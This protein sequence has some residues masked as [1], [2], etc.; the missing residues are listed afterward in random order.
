MFKSLY[1]KIMLLFAIF[2]AAVMAAV[3]TILMDS[4]YRFYVNEF[5][6]QMEDCLSEGSRSGL[7][8]ELISAL[9]DT[10]PPKA[11][12]AILTAYGTRLGIDEYRSFYILDMSGKTLAGSREDQNE[13]PPLTPNLISAMSGMDGSDTKVGDFTPTMPPTSQTANAPA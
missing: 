12:K 1:L 3:G 5:S 11:Q 8:D 2:M 13:N 4:V 10:D 7:R 6:A 9:G